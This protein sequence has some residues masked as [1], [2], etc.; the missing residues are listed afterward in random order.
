M[1]DEWWMMKEREK[2]ENKGNT[3]QGKAEK[4][5]RNKENKCGEQLFIWRGVITIRQGEA[6]TLVKGVIPEE[7]ENWRDREREGALYV[8]GE[9]ERQRGGGIERARAPALKNIWEPSGSGE[10]NAGLSWNP[11]LPSLHCLPTRLLHIQL[12]PS[13]KR[14]KGEEGECSLSVYAL[15][16]PLC[17]EGRESG[18]RVVNERDSSEVNTT[19]IDSSCLESIWSR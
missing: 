10:K 7:R 19:Q 13:P 8:K 17:K 6:S 9:L 15:L 18:Q 5:K 1:N 3:E 12:T 11:Q 2:G 16:P 14:H 4:Q